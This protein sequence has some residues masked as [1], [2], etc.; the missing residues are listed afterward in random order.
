MVNVFHEIWG[1][2]S[3][4]HVHGDLSG[5]WRC[6]DLYVGTTVSDEHIASILRTEDAGS[7]FLRNGGTHIQVNKASQP[8]NPRCTCDL[9][10]F[11]FRE[12]G[13]LPTE[14]NYGFRL[15]LKINSE[16]FHKYP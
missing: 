1:S 9:F 6:T 11:K 7:M 4:E 8:R 3:G 13:I 14:S 15:V 10:A 12:L 2:R 5:F 16:Y